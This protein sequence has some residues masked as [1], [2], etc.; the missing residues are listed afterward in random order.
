MKIRFLSTLLGV[1]LL[2][3]STFAAQ[4]CE[5]ILE[6]TIG[7]PQLRGLMRLLDEQY[8]LIG[9]V[10]YPEGSPVEWDTFESLK[11]L[12]SAVKKYGDYLRTISPE[13][14]REDQQYFQLY[15]QG[16]PMVSDFFYRLANNLDLTHG[17]TEYA[18]RV[19]LT[20]KI[21][22]TVRPLP[23]QFRPRIARPRVKK[24]TQHIDQDAVIFMQDFTARFDQ[25][26][27][28]QSG[29]TNYAAYEAKLRK[30][31][32]IY[33]QQ[34]LDIID[35]N[36]IEIV[37]RR[38]ERGR[39]WIPKV[40]FQNQFVTLNSE[41]TYD[42]NSRNQ[43]ESNLTLS[44]L[45]IYEDHLAEFK[46]K[47]GTMKA[48]KDSGV[49]S[50]LTHT[51]FYG[52]DIY[53]FKMDRISDRLSFFM[54]DSLA[55]GR[56]GDQKNWTATFIPWPRRLIMVPFLALALTKNGF[57]LVT[58]EESVQYQEDLI[59]K[60]SFS[61]QDDG[62]AGRRYWETQ[63]FGQITLDMVSSFEFRNTPPEGEFLAELLKRKITIYDGRSG[64][65]VLW[66]PP[67]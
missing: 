31:K 23:P 27:N 18:L 51:N 22:D 36:Q 25:L 48:S 3:S 42:R 60:E 20:Q 35:R 28:A 55:T 9:S 21:I 16:K 19:L 44:P 40:G 11:I 66:E 26:F 17:P 45:K 46:A 12:T 2:T 33:I 39:F 4:S 54:D 6:S 5:Q 24:D 8:A 14:Q 58:R 41:G 43:A 29:Y 53:T 50:P 59:P 1:F 52:D 57:D 56:S 64:T 47:Y 30:I 62:L 10:G 49:L 61:F 37:V 13:M 38:P 15:L 65:P 67:K 7:S 32:N 63:I 34:A